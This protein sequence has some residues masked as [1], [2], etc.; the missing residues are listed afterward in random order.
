[1]GKK[2]TRAKYTSKGERAGGR[3]DI[4]KASRRERDAF[5]IWKGKRK[6][7]RQGKDVFLTIEGEN[8]QMKRVPA[9]TV[10][11]RPDDPRSQFPGW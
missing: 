10:W 7:W 8:G 9:T 3:R 5:S 6:A 1:M 4:T 2:R 11:G